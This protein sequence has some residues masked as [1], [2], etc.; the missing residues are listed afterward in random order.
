MA[1]SYYKSI[2][3]DL[4]TLYSIGKVSKLCNISHRT[5]RHYEELGLIKPDVVK[6][7]GYRY[8][9]RDTMLRIPIIKYLKMMHFSLKQ[10][11]TLLDQTDYSHTLQ[12]FDDRLSECKNEI[13]ELQE[14]QS[15]I[16]DWEDLIKEASMVLQAQIVN[17]SVKYMESE[18]YLSMPYTFTNDYADA[19]INLAFTT[20]VEGL[21]NKITG[22]V[23]MYVPNY[24]EKMSVPHE[25]ESYETFV[26][27]K[28]LRPVAPEH[29]FVRSEGLYASSY[30]IG[31]FEQIHLT[32]ERMER[33]ASENGHTLSHQSLERYVT[34]YWTTRDPNLFVTEVCIPIEKNTYEPYAFNQKGRQLSR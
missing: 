1:R 21:S 4:G 28:A 17:V 9:R 33:W 5:L 13:R 23:M 19:T 3:D 26:I 11:V 29:R 32:Y 14:R 24:H 22:P 8:Y 2:E 27:Q 7:N 6:P 30:H 18:E 16:L 12:H 15:I 31:D 10:M 34:D 25:Q 20:F